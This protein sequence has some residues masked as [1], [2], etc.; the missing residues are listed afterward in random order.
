MGERGLAGDG[1]GVG[2]LLVRGDTGPCG[3]GPSCFRVGCLGGCWCGGNGGGGVWVR[4]HARTR[5][6]R[7]RARECARTR[8][9]GMCMCV[10]AC[11][12][13]RV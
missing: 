3:W 6:A 2:G 13:T 7:A 11:V 9:P 12:R 4:V 10:P 1:A 5:A 8:T